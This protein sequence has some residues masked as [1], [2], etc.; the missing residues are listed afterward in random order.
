[1]VGSPCSPRDSQESSPTPTFKSINSSALSFFNSPTL[2]SIHDYWKNHCFHY[3]DLCW[4]SDVSAFEYAVQVGQSFSSK[5]QASFNFMT[6]VTSALIVEPKRIKS[7][8]ISIVSPS[9]KHPWEPFI[10]KLAYSYKV[11]TI[12]ILGF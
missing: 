3:M 8:T 7:V 11:D 9:R 4:Q 10:Y 5:K 6:E 1:M 2:T 12:I